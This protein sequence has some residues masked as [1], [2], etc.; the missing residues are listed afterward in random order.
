MSI[1]L[2][3]E[4]LF[5]ALTLYLRMHDDKQELNLIVKSGFYTPKLQL[6]EGKKVEERQTT[7]KKT[8]PEQEGYFK[9][10]YF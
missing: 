9:L 1:Q 4:W 2:Y 5:Q 7:P 6:K 3:Y 8:Y 10:Q